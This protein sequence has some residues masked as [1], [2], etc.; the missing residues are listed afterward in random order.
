M[1]V[2]R[3]SFR[4]THVRM[5]CGWKWRQESDLRVAQGLVGQRFGENV[6]KFGLLSAFGKTGFV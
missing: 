5:G 4:S 1:I 6:K 2:Q 3:I